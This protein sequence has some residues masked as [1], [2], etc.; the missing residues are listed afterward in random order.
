[1]KGLATRTANNLRPSSFI[2]RNSRVVRDDKID[3]ANHSRVVR[4]D[5]KSLQTPP[6]S[7]AKPKSRRKRLQSLQRSQNIRRKRLQIRLR[8]EEE[9]CRL[10]GRGHCGT[11]PS[12]I[13]HPLL[14]VCQG[15]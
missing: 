7:S 5:K 15:G 4:D 1:M 12:F 14:S 2:L 9:R 6:E 11:L 13:L 3:V 10:G 8:D